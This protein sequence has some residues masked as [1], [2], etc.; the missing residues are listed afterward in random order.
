VAI[1]ALRAAAD[2]DLEATT[3]HLGCERDRGGTACQSAPSC[4]LCQQS[5]VWPHC[6]GAVGAG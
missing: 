5:A 1:A 2:Q 4:S 6:E 3:Y